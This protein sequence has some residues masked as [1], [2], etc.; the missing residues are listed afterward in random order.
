MS[1]DAVIFHHPDGVETNRKNLMG[2]HAAGE[3]FLRGYVR[4]SGASEF[5]AHT[6]NAD[7]FKDFVSRIHDFS[8]LNPACRRIDSEQMDGTGVPGTLMLPGPDLSPFAWRRRM[9][10]NASYSLC[11]VNHT[12]S[13]ARVMDS[14]GGLV[15]SPTMA[16]DALIC[17]SQSSR[18]AMRHVMDTYM[19]YLGERI[20]VKPTLELQMPV[21]PLGVD[22]G[23]F[24]RS[25]ATLADRN[26]LRTGLGIATDD[27]ALLFVGRLSFHAKAHPLAMYVA[28]EAAA[29]RSG[30]KVHI[31]QAGWFA[32]DSIEREFREA[33]HE[34]CPSVNAIFLD[35][36]DA[37]VRRRIWRAADIFVSLSDN[38]QETF[39]LTPIEAMA[40]GIPVVVSDWD[41]YRE[42]VNDGVHG[43]T[44]PT[45]MPGGG[46]GEDLIIAPE[47]DVL[48]SADDHVYDRYCGNV[49][50]ATV[51]DV[52]ACA[53]A[54]SMLC[55]DDDK[56][57]AMGEAG[58]VRAGEMY[59]WQV[60]IAQ[61]Q[62]LWEDLEARRARAFNDAVD[63]SGKAAVPPLRA[64]PFAMF[65]SYAT[66]S[67]NLDTRIHLVDGVEISSVKARLAF[68]M[69]NFALNKMMDE[70]GLTEVVKM[71]ATD[72]SLNVG[73][74][75]R[76][77]R[78]WSAEKVSRSIGWLAKMHIVR[79]T[80][81]GAARHTEDAAEQGIQSIGQAIG[82]GR[83]DYEDALDVIEGRALAQVDGDDDLAGLAYGELMSRAMDARSIGDLSLV[84]T[85]LQK[86]SLLV[87]DEVDVNIQMG[88]LLAAG[89][90]YDAAIACF[91]RAEA[92]HADNLATSINL[93]KVLYLRGDESEGIHSFRKAVRIA[94]EDGEARYLLGAALRRAGAHSEAAQSLRLA[95]ELD[96]D[97]IEAR[98]H[99]GL[100]YR[101]LDRLDDAE[102]VFAAALRKQPDNRFIQAAIL[103]AAAAEAGARVVKSGGGQKIAMHLSRPGDFN[104]LYPLFEAVGHR[105]WPMI[106]ADAA[107]IAA[108]GPEV[109][110]TT[111]ARMAALRAHVPGAK[112]VH[113]PTSPVRHE[114]EIS[115]CVA[116]DAVCAVTAADQVALVAAG[117]PA[118]RVWVAGL[119]AA[120]PVFAG[121]TARRSSANKNP[122]N[123]KRLLFAPSFRPRV[124]AAP[125]LSESLAKL[126]NE[127]RGTYHVTIMPDPI[128]FESQPGWIAGWRAMVAGRDD[129][130]LIE[131]RGANVIDLMAGAEALI[132][133]YSDL[134]FLFLAFD[135]PMILL[136]K[137][138]GAYLSPQQTALLQSAA[139]TIAEPDMLEAALGE[140]LD[141]NALDAEQR[142]RIRS[143]VFDSYGDGKAG[144]RVIA[145]LSDFLL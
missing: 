7:H 33:A 67:I 131:D 71:L 14:L 79:L 43:F 132:S 17:T 16:W 37:D 143:V 13:S 98:Y 62:D 8:D 45:W 25:A 56:R 84:A 61:Y 104:A 22:C 86:A 125:V 118:R 144:H 111:N 121:V 88:E 28:T 96:P 122:D 4:H 15:T 100:A 27:I 20:G 93:G 95:T 145:K 44:V 1:R 110:L 29:R 142:A 23:A 116:A 134:A 75:Q 49:S 59:D 135:K 36:R 19:E 137:E 63:A 87:P 70:A 51:V 120:D 68:S 46:N 130:T 57:H 34:F 41:G 92:S 55:S 112:L 48:N 32:N 54:L 139:H 108:F 124:S 105:H 39:G 101:A 11:G 52:D 9:R 10:G 26:S 97:L 35:G 18:S 107:E 50:Q 81:S 64:D 138:A 126:C 66:K 89:G 91:R 5:H 94:P 82:Q 106:S 12:V 113:I 133:D 31:I 109:V 123:R 2:R 3:G 119:P 69:N 30:K 117:I 58:R 103:T 83:G 140:V 6:L 90:R 47:L 80:S 21:I 53:D 77:M 74:I 65:E 78:D 102:Q 42:T 141:H 60:V 76:A 136:G 85:L 128:T 72:G 38:I 73:E 24:A 129:M 127:H 114:D 40:A 115:L 99:L